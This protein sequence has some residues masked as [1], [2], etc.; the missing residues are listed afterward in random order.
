MKAADFSATIAIIC[1]S[2]SGGKRSA[3]GGTPEQGRRPGAA[4]RALGAAA[5]WRNAYIRGAREATSA[6]RAPAYQAMLCAPTVAAISISTA[7]CAAARSATGTR[8]G[9][10]ET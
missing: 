3:H 8:N 1:V 9:E 7:A 10:Q 5:A 6:P 2:C 4:T